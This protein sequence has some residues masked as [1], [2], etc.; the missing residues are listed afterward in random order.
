M[1]DVPGITVFVCNSSKCKKKGGKDLY[2]GLKK[3]VKEEGLKSKVKLQK[4]DCTGNC[5]L[6]PVISLQPMNIW[7]GKAD[8][9][10]KEEIMR[11]I[12]KE[13]EKEGA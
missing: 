3:D 4:T 2:R 7:Y 12:R 8:D 13:I 9:E 6:A 10:T 1:K 11:K 5:K